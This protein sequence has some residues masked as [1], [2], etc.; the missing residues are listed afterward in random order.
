MGL[1]VFPISGKVL[2]PPLGVLPLPQ[3]VLSFRLKLFA[4]M[5]QV[6]K[7]VLAFGLILFAAKAQVPE[8]VQW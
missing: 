1:P 7:P 3:Q 2:L 6:P 5:A 8:Q 4:A